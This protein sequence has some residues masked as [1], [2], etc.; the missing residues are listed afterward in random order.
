MSTM[1]SLVPGD[2]KFRHRA[3]AFA[4]CVTLGAFAAR[5]MPHEWLPWTFLMGVLVALLFGAMAV[6]RERNRP[7]TVAR[8]TLLWWWFLL[9]SACFIGLGVGMLW[10]ASA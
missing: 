7:A 8:P 5:G 6:V 4:G 2:A 9:A 3:S 10:M 1:V